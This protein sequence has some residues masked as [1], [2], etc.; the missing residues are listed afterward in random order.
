MAKLFKVCNS[1]VISK[2]DQLTDGFIYIYDKN[3]KDLTKDKEAEKALSLI[4]GVFRLCYII[5][6]IDE[7]KNNVKFDN[8][9]QT[10]IVASPDLK[11][12]YES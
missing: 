3:K 9:F 11:A 12:M 10:A 8:W 5:N 4:R 6:K 7:A 2:I 1:I